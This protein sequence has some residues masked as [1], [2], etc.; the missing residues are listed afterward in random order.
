MKNRKPSAKARRSAARLA[1]VQALYQSALVGTDVETVV[2][3]FVK[4][5][6]GADLDGERYVEPEPTLFADV[7]RGTA[8]RAGDLDAMI[9]GA[10]DRSWSLDRL[11]LL[12]RTILRAGAWELLAN[13]AVAPRI[14]IAEYVDVAYAFFGGKEPAMVNAVLDRLARTLRP[15][16]LAAA[17][18]P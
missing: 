17:S 4:H 10:L 13:H 11:E 18:G 14:V 12:L 6:F 16:E 3:E 7:V 1:A 9:G 8:V 15:D 5:R 2:G